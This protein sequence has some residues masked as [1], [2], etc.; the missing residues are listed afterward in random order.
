M[1]GTLAATTPSWIVFCLASVERAPPFEMDLALAVGVSIDPCWN[2]S[3]VAC[4]NQFFG[5]TIIQSVSDRLAP[6][7]ETAFRRLGSGNGKERRCANR[8]ADRLKQYGFCLPD[9]SAQWRSRAHPAEEVCRVLR[10]MFFTHRV[11]SIL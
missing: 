3:L 6:L 5:L 11:G 7:T 10:W 9:H 1:P 4:L 2:A 8:H